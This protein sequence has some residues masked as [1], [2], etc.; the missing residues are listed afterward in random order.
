MVLGVQFL[1]L[2]SLHV[3]PSHGKQPVQNDDEKVT[4]NDDDDIHGVDGGD[5][6]PLRDNYRDESAPLRGESDFQC[7]DD[8]HGRDTFPAPNFYGENDGH[9]DDHLSDDDVYARFHNRDALFASVKCSNGAKT[10]HDDLKEVVA[11]EW[12]KKLQIH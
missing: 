12:W 1:L 3:D 7:D 8:D 6:E 2:D 4:W 5:C 10:S 9:D 11:G